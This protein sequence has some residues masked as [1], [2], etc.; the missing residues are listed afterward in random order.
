[1]T[2]LLI[3][4]AQGQ[5][6]RAL[7]ALAS[8]AG[9][10]HNALGRVEC[11]ITS[12]IAVG[13]A[14]SGSDFVVNCAAYTGVDRAE[15]EAEAAR[16]VNALGPRTIAAA[17]AAAG[18]PLIHLSTDYVFDGESPRPSREGDQPRPLS[19]YGQS[20]LEGEIAVRDCLDRHIILRTSRIFS[21]NGQ[22]FVKTILR[23][24]S[25]QTELRVVDD[26]VGGPTA[27][28][29][30]AKAIL[31]IVEIGARR[32]FV[33]WG[34]YH[35]SGAPAVSWYTFARAIVRNSIPVVPIAT[36]DYPRPA[37]RPLNSVLDCS[38]I[39]DVFGIAQPDWRA[40]L[41]RVLEE[42]TPEMRSTDPA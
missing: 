22:N 39:S 36:M 27:A 32:G 28:D 37:R 20:K 35:F 38:R 34:T 16:T 14:V 6:G 26:Q 13:R 41:H 33:D 9:V 1:M 15:T 2:S 25:T 12:P 8:R 11:D 5:V 40:A 24:A 7:L 3:L 29:D 23:L 17:C 18:I 42:L 30:I 19:V 4:G 21:A 10:P 31:R